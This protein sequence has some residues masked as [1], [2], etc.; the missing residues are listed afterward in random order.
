VHLDRGANP[1]LHLLLGATG[2]DTA[3][4]VRDVRGVPW[5]D[6]AEDVL[7]GGAGGPALALDNTESTLDALPVVLLASPDAAAP[8]YCAELIDGEPDADGLR[9]LA[10]RCDVLTV[11]HELVDLATMRAL[12]DEGHAVRPSAA[13]LAVANDK[14]KQRELL[15][16]LGVP[17]A[18]WILTDDLDEVATF[19]D[20]HGWGLVLKRPAGGYDGRGVFVVDRRDAAAAVLDEVGPL[21]PF[22]Y[23][24]SY[25]TFDVSAPRFET[26]TIGL[27]ETATVFVDVTITG[28]RTGYEVVQLYVRDDVAMITRPVIELKGFE[29]VTLEPGETRTV[30]FELGFDELSLWNLQMEREVE[31]GTFTISAGPNSVDLQSATLTVVER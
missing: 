17:V 7:V 5:P 19:A 8:P 22:G 6:A 31:P 15:E 1:S 3:G 30:E 28:D 9:A 2:G 4:K 25:T 14:V 12:A 21:F 11:E 23:G 10:A 16:P 27:D 20:E 26:A 13:A 18:P 29:R 24:L